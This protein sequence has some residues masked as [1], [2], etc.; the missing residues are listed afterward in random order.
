MSGNPRRSNGHARRKLRAWVRSRR[1]SCWICSAF[2]RSGDPCPRK[3]YSSDL[4][5]ER[6]H[7]CGKCSKPMPVVDIE[8]EE[9]PALKCPVCDGD[10]SSYGL[11]MLW[12]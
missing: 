7:P 6:V 12:D 5:K 3:R 8:S 10:L 1:Q 11:R 4:V 9:A 2:G